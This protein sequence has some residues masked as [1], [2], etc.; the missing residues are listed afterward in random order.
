MNDN[1]DAA[2]E[3]QCKKFGELLDLGKPVTPQVMISAIHDESY[4]RNLVANKKRPFYLNKL[5][6]DPPVVESKHKPEHHY[7]STELISS[8][9]E[10][11]LRWSKSGFMKVDE[12]T[13]QI[14]ENACLSCPNMV[15]P[16]K[17][18]QK[19]VPSK[20]ISNKIGERTGNHI[21]DLCGCHIGK[22]ILLVT[23]KCPDRHPDKEGLTRWVEP[24]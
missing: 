13:L 12:Q 7:S 14:R 11:L 9:V 5:L 16:D 15:D 18:L 3:D 1:L 23:E 21:C 19:L 2:F 10:A 4:A 6:N 22:K 24:L 8:A 17:F 20:N